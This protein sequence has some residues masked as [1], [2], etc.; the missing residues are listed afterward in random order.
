[1]Q[2]KPWEKTL[3]EFV[4]GHLAHNPCGPKY[5]GGCNRNCWIGGKCKAKMPREII[6]KTDAE[7]DGY[8]LYRR[9]TNLKM[10]NNRTKMPTLWKYVSST[11]KDGKRGKA[12]R[13][14]EFDNQW[15][16]GNTY[17]Y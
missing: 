4:V 10:K 3:P 12:G 2:L 14:H 11:R 9:R 6:Q 17:H 1:M 13:R 5:P 8:A 15:I 7:V 16:P